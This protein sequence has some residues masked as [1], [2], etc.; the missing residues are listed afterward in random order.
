[1]GWKK[2]QAVHLL[3]PSEATGRV[4][5]I[6]R[7]MQSVLGV[8]HVSSFFQFLGTC[9]RF[10]DRFWTAVR[11]I[12]Q[13]EVFFTCAHRLRADAYTRVHTYFQIPDLKG[14]IARQQFSLGAREELK[15]CIN[16]FCYSVPM[17]LLL[18]ALL[19]RS[20]EG[21]AGNPSIP[22]TPAPCHKPHRRIVMVEEDSAGPTVK[23][24]FADIRFATGADVIHTVYRAFARWPDFL[25]SY[26]AAVKPI[27]VSDLFQ[28]CES[29]LRE[30]AIHTVTELPGPVE[31]NS[32]DMAEIGLTESE[33]G[34]LIRISDMFFHSLAAA[35]LNVS[36]ARIAIEGGSLTPEAGT[37][38]SPKTEIPSG[39]PS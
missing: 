36:V 39:Q 35:L 31:F 30:E 24:I 7:D 27:A 38:A 1:M 2:G 25:S 34:S 3:P 14:E 15:D 28:H 11:P 19:T 33:T 18:A 17:S 20:F 29:A 5:E 8:P 10:L 37:T 21:P 6:Y 12:A 13:T 9:P 23:G 32:A 22:R 16:F 4:L 26:W